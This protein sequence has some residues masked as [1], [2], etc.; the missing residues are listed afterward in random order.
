MEL[1]KK[2]VP[3]LYVISVVVIFLYPLRHICLGVDVWDGGYNYANASFWSLEYMDSMWFFATW[4]ANAVGNLLMRLPGGGTMLGMNVYT[5]LII[6]CIGAGAYV[7]CVKKLKMP[8]WLAFAGELIALSLCWVPSSALYNYLTYGLVLAGVLSL[9]HGL[10]SGKPLFLVLAGVALGLNVGVRFSNLAQAGLIVVVWYYGILARKKWKEVL[11]D[12]GWCVLGYL[13][14][15]GLF[16]LMISCVYGLSSYIEGIRQLFAMTDTA[17]DY[18]AFSMLEGMIGAYIAPV[19]TYWMKRVG[20]AGVCALVICLVLPKK[21]KRVKQILTL[22]IL[23]VLHRYLSSNG[24]CT[25]N[26]RNYDSVYNHCVLFFLMIIVL[27][28]YNMCSRKTDREEKVQALLVVL[29]LCLTSLGGNNA[30]YASI[31]NL[32][33]VAPLMLWMI[34]GFAKRYS[35][36]GYYPFQMFLTAGA[37]LLLVQSVQFGWYFVYE[38]ATGG[39]NLNYRIES[40]PVLKGMYTNEESGKQLEELYAYLQE[41]DLT[42]KECIL[43]GNIPGIAYYMQLKPAINCWGDL[44]SYVP[45]VFLEDL[46]E[47]DMQI[48]GGGELPVVILEK[49]YM[50]YLETGETEGILIDDPSV[51]EKFEFLVSF[52]GWYRYEKSYENDK[53]VVYE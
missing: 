42:D 4:I 51:L 52:M 33:L 23:L 35:H 53:Y 49:N 12:T 5:G 30:M 43:Y 11:Q 48:L 29:I 32:F 31:N 26:F 19:N 37:V 47:A 34:Y 39:W 40:V 20:L 10:V 3:Y 2:I 8:A 14:A 41:N 24:Y 6:G 25:Q 44:R 18:S 13:V 1:K 15:Y 38:G 22:G 45:E 17:T 21:W 27:S 50:E 28:I 46:V 9:Y 16:L 36:A 7:F